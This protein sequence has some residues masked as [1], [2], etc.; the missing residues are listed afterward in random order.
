MVMI[1]LR[2]YNREIESLIESNQIDEAIS[3]CVTILQSFPKSIDTY[4][5][6]GK[7][8]LE[9]KRYSESADV[10][11]KVLAAYPDD[12]ISHI[13]LSVIEEENR[14]LDAAIW[15]MEQ[16]FELQPSNLALQEELRRLIGRRDGVPPTKIRLTRGALVKMYAR[17]DLYQQAIAEIKSVLKDEPNRIDFKVLL[18]KM[19]HVSGSSADAVDVAS[20]IVA[21][22]PYCYEANRILYELLP[23]KESEAATN[24]YLDRLISLDPY[25]QYVDSLAPESADVPADKIMIEK[26]E[27]ASSFVQ[28]SSDTDWSKQLGLNW[29]K[30]DVFISEEPLNI[31]NQVDAFDEPAKEPEQTPPVSPFIG[32]MTPDISSELEEKPLNDPEPLPDWITKAGWT[33]PSDSSS[34]PE[35][36]VND[37]ASEELNNIP[38]E[39][40]TE[41][42]DWLKS[43]EPE[44]PE[45]NSNEDQSEA[46]SSSI[47]D[48]LPEETQSSSLSPEEFK[49]AIS[50]WGEQESA[51]EDSSP[52]KEPEDLSSDWLKQFGEE[53]TNPS[54]EN[55]DHKLP[56]WL[57][58]FVQDEESSNNST[59]QQP[60]WLENL[61]KEENEN[62]PEQER[63]ETPEEQDDLLRNLDEILEEEKTEPPQIVA[64]QKLEDIQVKPE[65]GFTSPID[66]V[67]V[68]E[69]EDLTPE[70]HVEDLLNPDE[71]P[72][73][74]NSSPTSESNIPSWV[75]NI[76]AATPSAAP[77]EESI[78]QIPIQETPTT[79]ESKIEEDEIESLISELPESSESQGGVISDQTN[80][81]L[82]SWLRDIN[83]EIEEP[84]E[85]HLSKA[86]AEHGN[87]LDDLS[88]EDQMR[89]SITEGEPEEIPSGL[90]DAEH[91]LQPG[92]SSTPEL[93]DRLSELLERPL[94]ET[95]AKEEVE[96]ESE[97]VDFLKNDEVIP[98]ESSQTIDGNA[99]STP[100]V[101]HIQADEQ[102]EVVAFDRFTDLLDSGDYSD[103]ANLVEQSLSSG[104]P[105]DD[106]LSVV[107]SQS[108]K[109]PD[110]YELWQQLGDLY[111]EKADFD[112]ALMAYNKAAKILQIQL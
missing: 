51:A 59:E 53:A 112:N 44:T 80:D 43:F 104:T 31:L 88:I 20:E 64:E 99:E 22:Y 89:S 12:F 95:V 10:F 56:D 58:N 67:K 105:V 41:L 73:S 5:N 98:S 81:D 71:Q 23:S 34:S 2:D 45:I 11:S 27:L 46:G 54:D 91:E 110:S 25:Y 70:L 82:I 47:S 93:E 111:L 61:P 86:D 108:Q 106:L 90:V 8:L 18:A 84:V 109:K 85:D 48:L 38:A 52:N 42:P 97:I 74:G 63:I 94:D 65:E 35:P 37:S 3:H 9:S 33:R 6:L 96:E 107:Q 17:G 7:A 57:I 92:E 32:E 50:N 72:V 14:N 75:Q 101:E 15:H 24:V 16:A 4:R 76:L 21:E 102:Q 69:T 83:P 66:S 40:S 36:I 60:D 1:S 103:L 13:G 39:P 49:D 79:T 30:K 78:Q 26:Q 87:N 28:E 77:S 19:Y 62:N 29:Q 55:A 100:S 68:E